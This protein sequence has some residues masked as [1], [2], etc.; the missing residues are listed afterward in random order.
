M[1]GNAPSG[2]GSPWDGKLAVGCFLPFQSRVIFRAGMVQGKCLFHGLG[3]SLDLHNL[4]SLFIAELWI[5]INL[6]GFSGPARRK[7]N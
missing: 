1:A 5:E 7:K 2:G 3:K 6:R 4:F